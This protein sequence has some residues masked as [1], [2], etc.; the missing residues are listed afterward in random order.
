M[1]QVG[2]QLGPNWAPTGAYFGMLLG[3]TAV[4]ILWKLE[5]AQFVFI[6]LSGYLAKCKRRMCKTWTLALDTHLERRVSKK[7]DTGGYLFNSCCGGKNR[8]V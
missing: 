4:K 2:P 1:G 5:N 3:W 8:D 7:L 6:F